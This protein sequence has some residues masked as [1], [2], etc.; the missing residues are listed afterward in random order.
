MFSDQC[1]VKDWLNKKFYWGELRALVLEVYLLQPSPVADCGWPSW[2]WLPMW[3]VNNNKKSI[4]VSRRTAATI[5]PRPSPP[6]VGAKAPRAAET[7][8]PAECRQQRS[9][10]YPT[11]HGQ[12]VPTLSAQ[13]PEALTP[14]WVKRPGDLDLWPWKWCP[15]H[16]WR[17]LPLCHFWCS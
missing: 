1:S 8:A 9:S 10:R 4:Q 5:C 2:P 3:Y 17:G 11:S 6:S 15:S 12:Y 13:L 7:T 16:V 14:R